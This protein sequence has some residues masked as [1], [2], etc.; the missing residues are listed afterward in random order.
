MERGKI[1]SKRRT[2]I[3]ENYFGRVSGKERKGQTRSSDT[4]KRAQ[5][6]PS[7]SCGSVRNK[8]QIFKRNQRGTPQNP[9]VLKLFTF[10]KIC[11]VSLSRPSRCLTLFQTQMHCHLLYAQHYTWHFANLFAAAAVRMVVI[12]NN[13]KAEKAE[14][15]RNQESS[16]LFNPIQIKTKKKKK[17]PHSHP[18]LCSYSLQCQNSR[19]HRQEGEA[20]AEKYVC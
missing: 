13:S 2:W 16:D 6:Q 1:L 18:S 4:E 9:L 19:C 20:I 7:Y 10:P 12:R 17:E 14:A 8:L 11:Q 3:P 5:L 15:P